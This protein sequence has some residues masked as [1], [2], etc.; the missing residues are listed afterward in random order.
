M[1]I[2]VAERLQGVGEYY[3]SQKLR[4]IEQLNKTG[5]PVINLGIGSPDMPPH[6]FVIETL[7]AET[8]K[9]NV[10]GYQSYKG[11]QTLRNGFAQWYKKWYSVDLNADTEILPLIGSKEGI[12]H[13]CM[14]Y[15]NKGDVVLV[16]NP[17][18]PT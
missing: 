10:H 11:V 8:A 2:Q 9:A 18:Y 7:A 13:I 4:E 5:I 6:P 17:G 14:T 3:F 1:E 12:M 15:I 16:P